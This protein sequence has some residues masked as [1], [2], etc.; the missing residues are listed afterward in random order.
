MV[1]PFIKK[2]VGLAL[3]ALC[4]MTLATAGIAADSA[5]AASEASRRVDQELQRTSDVLT[6]ELDQA[7][8][9]I[10]EAERLGTTRDVTNRFGSGPE[11]DREIGRTVDEANAELRRAADRDEYT[12][13]R[14]QLENTRSLYYPNSKEYN[15]FTTQIEKLDNDFA[16]NRLN[17]FDR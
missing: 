3:A 17:T 1:S 8:N 15:Q 6:R 2:T 14:R 10:H 9:Q 13:K 16:E 4:S 11:I 12:F 7:T 5:S